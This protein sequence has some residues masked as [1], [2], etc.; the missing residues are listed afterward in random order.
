MH[1]TENESRFFNKTT[2]YTEAFMAYRMD[3]LW[4]YQIHHSYA[5]S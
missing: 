4:L 1:R 3:A 5:K 2:M